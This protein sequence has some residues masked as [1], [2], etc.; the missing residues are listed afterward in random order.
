MQIMCIVDE[1]GDQFLPP[2]DWVSQCAFPSFGLSEG[3][4]ILAHWATQARSS[5]NTIVWQKHVM[6]SR[7]E[8]KSFCSMSLR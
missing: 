1:Q 3:L 7:L 8:S 5:G 6:N 4:K 2:F